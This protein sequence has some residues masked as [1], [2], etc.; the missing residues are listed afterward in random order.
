VWWGREADGRDSC[1]AVRRIFSI[2]WVR[3][4]VYGVAEAMFADISI[5]QTA[6]RSQMLMYVLPSR[7]QVVTANRTRQKVSGLKEDLGLEGNQYSVLLSLFT[8]G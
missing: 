5:P 2:T 6:R 3:R 1:I 7:H 8:A 4:H